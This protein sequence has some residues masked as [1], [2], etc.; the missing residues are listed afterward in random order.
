MK[1]YASFPK[2]IV[3]RQKG[4]SNVVH[5]IDMLKDI[6][7]YMQTY[8]NTFRYTDTH[9]HMYIHIYIYIYIYVCACVYDVRIHTYIHI[10]TNML[11][12]IQPYIHR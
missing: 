10:G 5:D 1:L 12:F 9:T 8:I 6:H 11:T 2:K 3:D 7:T 4:C